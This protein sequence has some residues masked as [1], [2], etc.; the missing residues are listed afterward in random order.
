MTAQNC[1]RRRLGGFPHGL[2]FRSRAS[3]R[4]RH[5]FSRV[6]TWSGPESNCVL[7]NFRSASHLARGRRGVQRCPVPQVGTEVR[8][9][10][11]ELGI[12]AAQA[13]HWA[14]PWRR[15]GRPTWASWSGAGASCCAPERAAAG[16]VLP[17]L[18]VGTGNG[19]A[20]APPMR[21]GGP[22]ACRGRLRTPG[23]HRPQNRA[24]FVVCFLL[25]HLYTQSSDLC[26]FARMANPTHQYCPQV[27]RDR[28]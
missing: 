25:L 14:P 27:P 28:W 6:E 16:A 19:D 22:L 10:H 13:W 8:A 26:C 21:P 3:E 20:G 2:I 23:P 24:S 5:K 17:P 4:R 1:P 9:A 18:A 7:G 11:A 12:R 15:R